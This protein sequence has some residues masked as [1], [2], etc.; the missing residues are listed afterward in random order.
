MFSG[1]ESK[2]IVDLGQ[3]TAYENTAEL[4]CNYRICNTANTTIRISP[5][6]YLEITKVES[7]EA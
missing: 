6:S 1:L 5:I 2:P 7:R 4:V 3:D